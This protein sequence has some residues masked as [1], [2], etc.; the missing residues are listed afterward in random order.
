VAIPPLT[1]SSRLLVVAPHPD[2][3]TLACGVL[4]QQVLAAGGAARVLLLTDG[5]D[6]PWPQ[7]WL[8]RRWRV[9]AADRRRWGQRR[10]DEAVRAVARL[11]LPASA[12]QPLGWPDLGLTARLRDE[13]P[14]ALATLAAAA[15]AFGPT[16][17]AVPALGDRHPDHGAAHVL[18][19]LALAGRAAPLEWLAYPVHGGHAEGLADGPVATPGQ[20]RRKL[21]ALAEHATQMALSGGRMRRLASHPERFVRLDGLPAPGGARLPWRPPPPL[22][23]FLRLLLADA[24]GVSDRPWREAV[25]R[26]G[27]GYRLAAQAPSGPCFAK[28]HL[29]WP[30]PWIFDHWGWCRL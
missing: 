26:D 8:E 24:G 7:R 15:E 6:N 10:R 27:D 4:I 20:Q 5:D 28:L 30:S 11:G 19:R 18:C 14:A 2:D 23:P 17:I 3:E 29:D 25:E 13:R 16:L 1:A 9:D 12:L 22:H 21:A